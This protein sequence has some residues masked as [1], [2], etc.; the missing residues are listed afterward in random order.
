M[1][2]LPQTTTTRMP[3]SVGQG[4]ITM[5]AVHAPAAQAAAG[6]TAGDVWRV[7]RANTWLI[8]GGLIVSAIIG[9]GLN[10]VLNRYAA[11]Y[12]ARGYVQINLTR[13]TSPLLP[14]QGDINTDTATMNVEL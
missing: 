1:T 12:T 10:W 6:M 3:R 4:P 8:I 11:R 9:Y 14:D 5:P 2:T 7:I 13:P